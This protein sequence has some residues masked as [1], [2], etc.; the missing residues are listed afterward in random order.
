MKLVCPQ[1][2]HLLNKGRKSIGKFCEIDFPP[3]AAIPAK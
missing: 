2:T 1:D 3:C